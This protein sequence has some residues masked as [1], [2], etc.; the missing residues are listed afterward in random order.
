[1]SIIRKLVPLAGAAVLVA[2]FATGASAYQCKAQSEISV[3]AG[4]NQGTAIMIGR[5]LWTASVRAKHGLEWSVWSIAAAPAQ[6]CAPGGG[7]F[8]CVISA[9]PCKYV[10]P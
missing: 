5:S 6:N 7:G 2:A 3:G 8:Q 10:V 1:M 4:T 9:K